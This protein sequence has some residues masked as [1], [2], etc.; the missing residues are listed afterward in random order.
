MFRNAQ[1]FENKSEGAK[2]AKAEL[3]EIQ[4]DKEGEKKKIFMDEERIET[5]VNPQGQAEDNKKAGK[6]VDPVV[7][8]H[9]GFSCYLSLELRVF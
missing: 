8:N 9:N 4:A 7:D 2:F 5:A 1:F 3:K 6:G